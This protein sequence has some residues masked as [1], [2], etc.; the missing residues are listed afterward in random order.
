MRAVIQICLSEESPCEYVCVHVLGVYNTVCTVFFNTASCITCS[1]LWGHVNNILYHS[2]LLMQG[3]G[4][5]MKPNDLVSCH[6]DGLTDRPFSLTA[7][8]PSRQLKQKN[9][10][11]GLKQDVS[12]HISSPR[13]EFSRMWGQSTSCKCV[14]QSL[15]T[16]QETTVLLCYDK[17]RINHSYYISQGS[18]MCYVWGQ[19]V[20]HVLTQQYIISYV[21]ICLPSARRRPIPFQFLSKACE[22]K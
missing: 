1:S 5:R 22:Q 13:R 12:D 15:L 4:R 7:A 10:S 8:S 9:G 18:A 20:S 6:G 3:R 14:D 21:L 19:G 16:S 11:P 17:P 2:N